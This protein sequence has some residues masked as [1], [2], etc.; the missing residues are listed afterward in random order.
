MKT[1]KQTNILIFAVPAMLL[2]VAFFCNLFV[3]GFNWSLPDFVIAGILLFGTAF[4]ISLVVNSKKSFS[5]KLIICGIVLLV[6][7]LIWIELA[8]GIFGSPFA[9]S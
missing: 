8:V 3:E 5:S 6:L 1:L 9:G 2:A 4:V 7:I